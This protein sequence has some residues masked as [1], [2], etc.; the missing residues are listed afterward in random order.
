MG[1]E[2]SIINDI[3]VSCTVEVWTLG[4][5]ILQSANT[6]TPGNHLLFHH[7]ATWYDVVLKVWRLQVQQTQTQ[8][9]VGARGPDRLVEQTDWA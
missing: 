8:R 4:Q 3:E 1:A 7:A 6:V 9:F 5:G 2:L